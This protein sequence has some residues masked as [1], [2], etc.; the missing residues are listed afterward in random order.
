MNFTTH[1]Q[2]GFTLVEMMITV[3]VMAIISSIVGVNVIGQL[4]AWRLKQA[5]YQVLS[6]F[7]K[8]RMESV[9][10]GINVRI[11]LNQSAKTYT[12]WLDLN[13]NGSV[14]GGEQTTASIAA[15]PGIS[16]SCYPSVLTFKPNGTMT[17]AYSYQY[18][19]IYNAAQ[20]R[21]VYSFPSG[22]VDPWPQE[23]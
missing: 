7:R 9:A 15:I 20:Y 5:Q 13:R 22:Q 16:W 3:A 23:G 18:V 8:A 2:T 19:Y 11:T 1:K 12:T 14:D 21:Y 10:R 6:D 4:P 17:S